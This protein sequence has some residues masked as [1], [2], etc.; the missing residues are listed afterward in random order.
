[1]WK[2]A[3][4]SKFFGPAGY[5]KKFRQSHASLAV[6]CGVQPE[7]PFLPPGSL[8]NIDEHLVR[9]EHWPL[10]AYHPAALHV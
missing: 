9:Y 4:P 3:R 6:P 8:D 2:S 5:K 1:M 7:A 10:R